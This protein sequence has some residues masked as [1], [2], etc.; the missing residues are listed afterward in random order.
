MP[1]IEVVR[2]ILRLCEKPESLI[3]HVPDRPARDRRYA[4]AIATIRAETEWDPAWTFD[5]GLE[6]TILRYRANPGWVERMRSGEYL[7]YY[8]SNYS[9]RRAARSR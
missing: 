5:E 8:D 2:R 6:E 4:L 3:E 1:N 9:C 7:R